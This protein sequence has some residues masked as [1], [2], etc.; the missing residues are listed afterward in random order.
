MYKESSHS[1]FYFYKTKTSNHQDLQTET[2]PLSCVVLE[3]MINVD[4]QD[5]C[6]FERKLYG[7]V[8]GCQPAPT[9]TPPTAITPPTPRPLPVPAPPVSAPTWPNSGKG[10]NKRQLKTILNKDKKRKK[11]IEREKEAIKDVQYD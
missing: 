3:Q 2:G 5:R 4:N 8:C 6:R 9:A 1:I 11:L 7:S 10:S